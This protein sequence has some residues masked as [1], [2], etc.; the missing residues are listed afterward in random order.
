MKR[1]IR[2]LIVSKL[3]PVLPSHKVVYR[4]T[5]KD[6]PLLSN[7]KPGIVVMTPQGLG[8]LQPFNEGVIDKNSKVK[9]YLFRRYYKEFPLNSL[10]Q[11]VVYHSPTGQILPLVSTDYRYIY[12]NDHEIEY[13]IS[14]NQNVLLTDR[15][16]QINQVIYDHSKKRDGYVLIK[17]LRKGEI[18]INN[19]K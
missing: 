16:K 6:V 3:A 9:V 18:K 1:N 10:R 5:I 19:D 12:G 2:N 11:Y 13:R 15:C 14:T 4:G 8:V 7:F 17:A